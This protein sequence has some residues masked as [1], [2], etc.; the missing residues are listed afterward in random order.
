MRLKVGDARALRDGLLAGVALV[1][2]T[3]ALVYPL[4][5]A[6]P[7]EATGA[8]YLI[9]VM[10]IA[11]R[12][13]TAPGLAAALLSAAAWNFFHIPPT[14]RFTIA[15]GENWVALAVFLVAA[16]VVSRLADDARR[17][18]D[19]AERRRSEAALL[20]DLAREMLGTRSEA[21]ARAVLASRLAGALGLAPG[22][23]QLDAHTV[24]GERWLVRLE[25]EGRRLGVIQLPA[26]LGTAERETVERLAPSLAVL[27]AAA[28]RG[29]ELE[30]EAIEAAA[31]RRSDEVKTALLRAVSHDLRSP[32]TAISAAADGLAGRGAGRDELVEVIQSETGRLG[33]LVA[34][35]LDLSRLETGTARPMLDWCSLEEV[36]AAAI[37]SLGERAA[38]VE[39]AIEPGLPLVE[40]DAAQ[41]ERAVANLLDNAIRH[42]AGKQV[43][44]RGR[45]VQYRIRLEVSDRGPGIP[46]QDLESVFEP[47]VRGPAT[48]G[49][50]SG[51]GLAIAR[52]F[53]AA[54]SGRLWA[55]SRPGNGA[56]FVIEL[57][58]RVAPREPQPARFG[59]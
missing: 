38:S 41:L 34:N 42:G 1:A 24:S 8:V 58:V 43:D 7:V 55:E 23:V 10:A 37:G 6:A 29:A 52:G 50:G 57:P 2:L 46:Q 49:S 12:W 11:V 51:L 3:T 21:E 17:R 40:A 15:E 35:L 22:D 25:S 36:V 4:K 59:E 56:T 19:E 27:L 16:V 48:T 47:F 20:A 28:R 30:A 26:G 18:A 45:R 33:R 5:E 39:V 13:G 44:V 14:G 31:L 53:V 54:S 9:A 32:L